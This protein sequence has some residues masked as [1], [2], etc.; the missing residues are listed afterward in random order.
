MGDSHPSE[1]EL[2]AM[3]QDRHGMGISSSRPGFVAWAGLLPGQGSSS[4]GKAPGSPTKQLR[5][6]Q[7]VQEMINRM[8][9]IVS[10]DEPGADVLGAPDA[11]V[12]GIRQQQ[13]QQQQQ[14]Q[15]AQSQTRRPGSAAAAGALSGSPVKAAWTE[16]AA[17]TDG[18]KG[19]KGEW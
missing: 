9:D 2:A 4:P 19:I 7:Q 13:Q 16:P 6:L 11:T 8:E 1:E 5:L 12:A 10:A 15:R 3:L 14:Q 18:S 17:S